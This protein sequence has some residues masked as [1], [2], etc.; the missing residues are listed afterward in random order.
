MS[1]PLSPPPVTKAGVAELPAYVSNGLL[2]LRVLDVP[3]LSGVVLVNG[4]IGIEPVV[5]VEAAAR[6]PYPIGGDIAVDGLWLRTAAQQARVVDQRSDF[7][8]GDMRTPVELR[9]AHAER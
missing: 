1:S 9:R 8:S 5:Q 2:G 7:L 3:L 6:A 4:F